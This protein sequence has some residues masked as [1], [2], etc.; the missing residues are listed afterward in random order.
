MPDTNG[1]GAVAEGAVL[2]ALLATGKTVLVPFGSQ[3][4]D[5]VFE[6]AGQFHRVQVKNGR[7][8]RGVLNFSAHRRTGAARRVSKSYGDSIDYFGVYLSSRHA[9][10]LIPVVDVGAAKAAQGWFRLDPPR[11]NQDKHVRLAQQYLIEVG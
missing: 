9:C 2:A 4:Y 10:Y 11:N 1:V 5:L 3:S 6:E 8:Y 7:E